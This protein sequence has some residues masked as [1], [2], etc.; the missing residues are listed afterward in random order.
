MDIGSAL[1]VLLRRWLVVLLGALLTL[2]ACAY[3]YKTA[4]PRY[5][6]TARMILLLP[7]DARS[8]EEGSPFLYLPNGL[9]VLARV[10]SSAPRSRE[11]LQAMAEAGLTSQFEVGVDPS[12]P[13]FSISVEGSDPVNVLETRDWLIDFINQHLLQVQKE[14]G[15][16][17]RQTAHTRLYEAEDV[18]HRLGGDWMRSVLAALAAGGI[19]TLLAAFGIDGLLAALARRRAERRRGD[20]PARA[21]DG[22]QSGP[23]AP[24]QPTDPADSPPA[25]VAAP[26]ESSPVAEY[27]EP[28]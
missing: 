25:P 28:R 22:D 18:P 21:T 10:V 17:S 12:T 26:A 15:T 20:A 7:P 19:V 27:S 16:P 4:E 11:A 9:N 8:D 6:A 3:L 1:R 5:Q 2:G 13:I 24:D 23:A 14:E